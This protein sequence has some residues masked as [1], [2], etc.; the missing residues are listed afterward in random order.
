MNMRHP[1]QS[2]SGG[3]AGIALLHI[4]RARA[5]LESWTGVRPWLAR[6]VHDEISVGANACLY[7]GAPALAFVLHGAAGQPG[8]VAALER[9]DEGVHHVVRDRL[10]RAH[11]RM[12]ARRLPEL[13][14]FDLISGL[15]GL[16]VCLRRR[17]HLD[18]L[19][20]VLTYLVRLTEPVNA[21]PGW[22]SVGGHGRPRTP[23]PPGGHAN[24]GMAH[25]IVGPLALLA[26]SYREGVLVA[27]H[28][29]AITRICHWLDEWRQS[30]RR[31]VW[32]P[33]TVALSDLERGATDQTGPTRPSWCYGTTGIARAQQLA[34]LVLNDPVRRLDAENAF[35][36]CLS[37]P[38]Q[39]GLLGDRC[40]CH[41]TAGL[42][43]TAR[44]ISQDAE[45]PIPIALIREI[46]ESAP[47]PKPDGLLIG[48]A[49]VSL[50]VHPVHSDWDACLLLT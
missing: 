28:A 36:H 21:L 8:L 46:H 18:L 2:L 49:G 38:S 33:E 50:A 42:L 19:R 44:R 14:E 31:G 41:G 3:A 20:H 11:R 24:H 27:D 23:E 15:T 35:L 22:W 10:E 25:G 48:T 47:P 5:R 30:S 13:R 45:S 16:G 12:D 39:H 17:G 43:A 6:I 40:L 37:D 4:E 1:H 9:L 34:A 32:W 29:R 7:Y 26:L